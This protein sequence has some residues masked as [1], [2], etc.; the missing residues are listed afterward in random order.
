MLVDGAGGGDGGISSKSLHVVPESESVA[1]CAS[2]NVLILFGS[3]LSESLS[4]PLQRV[5]WKF[6]SGFKHWL[7][8]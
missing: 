1:S 2:S 7:R 3:G 4:S 5:D 8:R 6:L